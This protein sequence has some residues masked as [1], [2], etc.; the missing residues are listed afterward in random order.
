MGEIIDF[1][2]ARLAKMRQELAEEIKITLEWCDQ[3]EKRIKR[4]GEGA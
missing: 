4:E 3:V 1:Y 2:E